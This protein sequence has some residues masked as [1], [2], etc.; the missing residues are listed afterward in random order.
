MNILERALVYANCQNPLIWINVFFADPK[1]D[2]KEEYAKDLNLLAYYSRV[3]CTIF[4][5]KK[6]KAAK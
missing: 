1:E 6:Y 3:K 2:E 5:Y 4:V